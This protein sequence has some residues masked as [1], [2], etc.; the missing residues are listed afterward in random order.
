MWLE[1]AFCWT[2]VVVLVWPPPARGGW[3]LVD[4]RRHSSPDRCSPPTG[5]L[6]GCA[7]VAL[8][9]GSSCC[10]GT[11]AS[12]LAVSA[13][14]AVVGLGSSLSFRLVTHIRC[15]AVSESP[16]MATRWRPRFHGLRSKLG[17]AGHHLR[18]GWPRSQSWWQHVSLSPACDDGAPGVARSCPRSGWHGAKRRST[19]RT[20]TTIRVSVSDAPRCALPS[21]PLSAMR[22]AG[23][24]CSRVHVLDG[25]SGCF[26]L[27]RTPTLHRSPL[28]AR[29]QGWC[30]PHPGS[31]LA[32]QLS[33]S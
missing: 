18:R 27:S 4:D 2:F 1:P 28:H 23:P 24:A 12:S 7:V 19:Q 30:S 31:S 29:T 3:R 32:C 22:A 26:L 33:Q 14:A 20:T 25:G 9:W 10:A 6:A 13:D 17:G 5:W 16:R 8:V 21:G 15:G 11:F